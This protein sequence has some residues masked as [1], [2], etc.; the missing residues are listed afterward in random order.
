VA[1]SDSQMRAVNMKQ[2]AELPQQMAEVVWQ[3]GEL[4]FITGWKGLL[5]FENDSESGSRLQF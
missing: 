4:N 5:I 1:A 3:P 2:S